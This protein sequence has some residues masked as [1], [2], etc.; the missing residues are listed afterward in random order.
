[1]TKK[2]TTKK[3][4]KPTATKANPQGKKAKKLS[5]IEA[6]TKVLAEA[7][8]PMN[9]KEMVE[10]MQ[11]KKYWQS[12]NGKTPEATLYASILRNIRKGKETKFVKADRGKFKLNK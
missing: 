8:E 11:A 6:A 9:C 10:A 4:S 1:M 2:A 5:Q 7:K 12:P 3:A